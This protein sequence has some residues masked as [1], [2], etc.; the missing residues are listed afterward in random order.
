MCTAIMLAVW[1]V[2][3]RGITHHHGVNT[4]VDEREHPDRWR[5]VAHS[6]P[7]AHHSAC[8]VVGLESGAPL[9]LDKNDDGIKDLVELG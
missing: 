3:Q 5:H 7:H 2:I 6:C 4:R 9:S 8:V 1:S